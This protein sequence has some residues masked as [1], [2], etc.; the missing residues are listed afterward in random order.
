MILSSVVFCFVPQR[1]DAVAN[2][3]NTAWLYRKSFTVTGSTAGVQTNY[4]LPF[5]VYFAS[6]NNTDGTERVSLSGGVTTNTTFGRIYLGGKCQTDFD[7]LR[8]TKSDGITKLDA[9]LENKTNSNNGTVWV[10]LDYIP[11]SPTTQTFYIYY[12]NST[13]SSDWSGTNTFIIFDDFERGINGDTVGGNWTSTNSTQTLISTDHAYGGTR[14]LKINGTAG[15]AAVYQTLSG[16][17]NHAIMMRLWKEDAAKTYPLLHGNGTNDIQVNINA[18]ELVQYYNYAGVL[19]STGDSITPDTWQLLTFSQL[20]YEKPTFDILLQDL[21]IL[22]NGEMRNSAS[23]ANVIRISEDGNAAGVDIY[24]DNVIVMKY[25]NPEPTFGTFGAEEYFNVDDYLRIDDVEIFQSFA[26]DE[27]WLIAIRYLN[28]YPPYFDTYDVR[29]LFLF[30]LIDTTGVVVAQSQ[31]MAWGNK[32]GSIYLSA[33]SVSSLEWGAAYT[34]RMY[35][36]FTG[37]PYVDFDLSAEDWIGEDLTNLD[38]WVIS[39]AHIIEDYYSSSSLD[40]TTIVAERGEVLNSTGGAMFELGI[41]GLSLQRPLIFQTYT[42][43]GT[44]TDL[45]IDTSYIATLK[46]WSASWGDDGTLML[47]RWGALFGIDGGV[48]GSMFFLIPM[49]AL[50]IWAFIP[51]SSHAASILT[52]PI[53]VGSV[54]FGTDPLFIVMLGVVAVFIW[55]K[56]WWFDK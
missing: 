2:W 4:Q 33:S 44:S 43:T 26:E 8:F 35:G 36:T 20:Q 9:W 10:E 34:I 15:F 11:A 42:I 49:L 50:L 31:V 21:Y 41:S 51:S 29:K 27:D 53:L 38:S 40:L 5:H 13:I 12:G 54:F 24:F 37:N 17:N 32:P 46:N 56:Q 16:T 39:S 19:T 47:N 6:T 14:C 30:Q 55:I 3:Y 22:D 28:L 18:A 52:A 7:D 45:T 25:C 1:V 48:I 23:Y